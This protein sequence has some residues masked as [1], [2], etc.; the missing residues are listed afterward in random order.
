MADS[1]RGT[2]GTEETASELGAIRR[3]LERQ[4]DELRNRKPVD[5]RGTSEPIDGGDAVEMNPLT[6]A[7]PEA[8]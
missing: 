1:T 7:Q 6:Q 5:G 3:K 4:H 8:G 2:A